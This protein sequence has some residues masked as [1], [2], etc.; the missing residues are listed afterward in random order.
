[1][2]LRASVTVPMT[3]FTLGIT[4]F[5]SRKS[6]FPNGKSDVCSSR[7]WLFSCVEKELFTCSPAL[8][9]APSTFSSPPSTSARDRMTSFPKSSHIVP[10]RSTPAMFCEIGSSILLNA[11]SVSRK[12]CDA[13]SPPAANFPAISSAFSPIRLNP[14]TVVSEPSTALMLNSFIASPTLS[15]L[16]APFSAP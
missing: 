2:P 3:S 12:A 5:P 15:R 1:M 8:T 6:S 4:S 10:N 7:N 13:V 16:N 9:V 14:S 11:T